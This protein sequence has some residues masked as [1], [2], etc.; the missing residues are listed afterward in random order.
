MAKQKKLV[1][2]TERVLESSV[3]T[4][5]LKSFER[6]MKTNKEPYIWEG[7]GSDEGAVKTAKVSK[8]RN[9]NVKRADREY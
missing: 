9:K 8:E 3:V 2:V 7:R 4:G 6:M 1:D 5:R